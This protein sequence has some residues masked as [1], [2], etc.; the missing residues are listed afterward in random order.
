M[1]ERGDRLGD[2]GPMGADVGRL[3]FALVRGECGGVVAFERAAA[4]EHFVERD[5]EAVD[6]AARVGGEGGGDHLGRDVGQ[7][8]GDRA[9]GPVAGFGG[10]LHEAEVDQRGVAGGRNQNVG[11]LHVGVDHARGIVKGGEAI[12]DLPGDPEGERYAEAALA[13]R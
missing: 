10:G 7:R 5:A 12:G 13:R 11:R 4:G 3:G 9:R 2:V 8:A 1:D 6:V